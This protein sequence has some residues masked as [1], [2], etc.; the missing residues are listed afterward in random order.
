PDFPLQPLTGVYRKRQ[1]E[2]AVALFQLMGIAREDTEKRDQWT[3]KMLRV[4][5][6]PNAIIVS[7]D[8]EVSSYLARL[9]I[10]VSL[11]FLIPRHSPG[12]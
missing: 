10:L 8:E 11:C 9:L 7:M 4:F 12:Y 2:L 3:L 1:V 6:A 5:D